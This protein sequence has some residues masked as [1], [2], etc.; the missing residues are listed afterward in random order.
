[1]LC[2]IRLKNSC[3]KPTVKLTLISCTQL[4]H[5]KRIGR[6]GLVNILANQ[7]IWK[8]CRSRQIRVQVIILSKHCRLGSLL[9]V[10][11]YLFINGTSFWWCYNFYQDVTLILWHA[12]FFLANICCAWI[13]GLC[14]LLKC[15]C[16]CLIKPGF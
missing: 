11:I 14:D 5:L 12:D 2:S 6:A 13:F 3:N 7:M 1:M 4:T 10:T 8:C 9:K 16:K 15:S